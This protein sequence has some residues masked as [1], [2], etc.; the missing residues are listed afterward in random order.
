MRMQLLKEMGVV[1]VKQ[2]VIGTLSLVVLMQAMPRL[3][4]GVPLLRLP[5]EPFKMLRSAAHKGLKE[6]DA[7]V[8]VAGYV[9]L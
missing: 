9:S 2:M 7:A 6:E 1:R 3:F 5:F 8:D 4:G